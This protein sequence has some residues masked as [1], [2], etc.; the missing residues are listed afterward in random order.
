M[1]IKRVFDIVL[2]IMAFLIFSPLFIIISIIL[3]CT[4]EGEVF[5][6][7][8]RVGRYRVNF[9]VFK[10]ATMLKNS[11]NLPGGTLTLENDPRVLP[12]GKFLRKT[13]INELP[14]LLNI[15][16]G[17]MSIVGPRPLVPEGE[18]HYS[19]EA[20]MLIRSV[21]PGLTGIGSLML[22]DEEGYYAHRS[23]AIEFYKM[24]ISPF[25]E[26]LELW[27]VENRSFYLD[28]KILLFTAIAVVKPDFQ[29]DRHFRLL[30]EIPSSMVASKNRE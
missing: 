11:P 24:V 27:Y 20:S 9:E 8:T 19:R 10:F 15:I 25:K 4:G 23:D 6:K 30:P 28:L 22:R 2:S 3:K 21:R 17:D 7:Q 18:E 16:N 13:K 12:L 5:Y 29:V 14:Q 1:K 26:N